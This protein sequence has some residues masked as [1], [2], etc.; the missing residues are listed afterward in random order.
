MAEGS[1]HDRMAAVELKN[2]IVGHTA[3][4]ANTWTLECYIQDA[5][6]VLLVANRYH[7]ALVDALHVQRIAE[8]E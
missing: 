6:A 1:R 4:D 3:A 2:V 8:L 5:E 7:A